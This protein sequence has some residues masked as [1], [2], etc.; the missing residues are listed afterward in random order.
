[1]KAAL[2]ILLVSSIPSTLWADNTPKQLTLEQAE[3]L[4]RTA[5]DS[6]GLTRLKGFSL[7]MNQIKE[8]PDY[9]FFDVLSN[10]PGAQGVS[11]HYAVNKITGDV[12]TSFGCSRVSSRH[13]AQLQHKMRIELGLSDKDYRWHRKDSRPCLA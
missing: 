9:Y 10:Q 11:E 3:L 6:I 4:A 13:L 12:W 2:I 8:F 7:D 1:M 5:A